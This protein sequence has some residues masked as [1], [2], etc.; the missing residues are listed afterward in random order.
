MNVKFYR[1]VVFCIFSSLNMQYAYFTNVQTTNTMVYKL[2]F[3]WHS[4]MRG[5]RVEDRGSGPP[6]L[7]K[8]RKHIGC[9]SNT[10]P[11]P[12]KIIKLPRQQSMLDDHR[13]LA[14]RRWPL[15]VVIGIS[16]KKKK[17]ILKCGPHLTKLSGSAH[18]W[19][20][21]CIIKSSAMASLAN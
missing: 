4:G 16:L 5:S 7:L 10:A 14:G 21:I 8:N 15:I 11:D 1:A 17:N 19:N 6:P 18:E 13:S 9:L 20:S 12:L 3:M 2:C